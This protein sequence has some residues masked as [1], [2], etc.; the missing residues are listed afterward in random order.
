MHGDEDTVIPFG[1]GR[2]LFEQVAGPKRFVTIR[3]GDHNDLAPPDS[4]AYWAAI[5]AF[6]DN[7]P[8]P[9]P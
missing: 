7:L 4:P 1:L 5:D 8:R 2:A 3:G 9:S 6:V